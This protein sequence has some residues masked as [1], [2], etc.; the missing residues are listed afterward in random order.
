ML[1]NNPKK[2]Q[3]LQKQIDEAEATN[4]KIDNIPY[5]TC[6]I[7]E[8]LRLKPSVLTALPRVTPPNGISVD[9]IDIPGGIIVS[10]PVQ[11]IQRDPRYYKFPN[12]LIPERWA[13]ETKELS[14]GRVPF[15]AFGRGI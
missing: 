4:N 8:T 12:E 11:L 15:M 9:E 3:K 10:V 1:A 2:C 5:L 14:N 13:E 6:V 7:K